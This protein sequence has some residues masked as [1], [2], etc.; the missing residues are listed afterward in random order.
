MRRV[1]VMTLVLIS[2][3]AAI[4]GCATSRSP[5]AAASVPATAGA[6][7]T[8]SAPGAPPS[9]SEFASVS[10]VQA[11]SPNPQAAI[12]NPGTGTGDPLLVAALLPPSAVGRLRAFVLPP[13]VVA[14]PDRD[15]RSLFI[16]LRQYS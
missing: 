8:N 5:G 1:P 11:G 4:A 10:M 9:P 6:A 3:L 15:P 16:P 14:L 13:A 7:R 2:V 12:P